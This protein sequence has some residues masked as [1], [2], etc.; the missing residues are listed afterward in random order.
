[1]P[2]APSAATRE[3]AFEALAPLLM[4]S[5]SS[6]FL[7]SPPASSSALLHSIMPS[8]VSSRSS[9]TMPAVICAITN[10]SSFRGYKKGARTPLS[11]KVPAGAFWRFLGFLHLDE[12]LRRGRHH[13]VHHLAAALEDRVRH[14][15]GVEADG[16]GRV[17]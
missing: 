2:T 14:A 1:M 6:A 16:A 5:S 7:S 15:A 12:I 11:R 17:V 8:P 13:L 9:L 4:R 10:L 3:A